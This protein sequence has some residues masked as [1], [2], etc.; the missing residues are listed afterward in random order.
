[1]LVVRFVEGVRLR[2]S[3]GTV[4]GRSLMFSSRSVP[5]ALFAACRHF[6]LKIVGVATY[7]DRV[8]LAS[9]TRLWM[10]SSGS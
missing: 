6:P 1:M 2:E 4:Y 10:E 7:G 8:S 9:H 5:L 3:A